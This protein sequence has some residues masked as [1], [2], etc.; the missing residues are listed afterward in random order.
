[1]N[2]TMKTMLERRSVRSYT[3]EPV[4]EETLQEILEA[5]AY[6]PSGM[7]R[8]PVVMVVIENKE[9]RDRLSAM[10]AAVMGSDSD[11]FYGAPVVIAVLA[12]RSASTYLYDGALT[13]GN[14]MNA[15]YSAGI[16]SCWIHRAKEVFDSE[17]GKALLKEWGLN[18]DYEGIGHC[19][20]G[21]G[22]GERPQAKPR[23]DGNTIRIK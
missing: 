8:Q 13:M 19:I 2:E 18:G 16:D 21:H 5:G 23:K 15:A 10:N 1:M 12:D 14:L 20:L 17:D 9:L 22:T 7:G 11:P 4:A 3:T 6:A